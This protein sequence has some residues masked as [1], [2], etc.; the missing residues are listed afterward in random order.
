MGNKQIAAAL[1][2]KLSTIRTQLDRAFRWLGVGD[3]ET[4]ILHVFAVTLKHVQ[5]E[6]CPPKS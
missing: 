5:D 2:R 4:L 1:D 3:R 6:C